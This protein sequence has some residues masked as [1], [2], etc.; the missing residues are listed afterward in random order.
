[1]INAI[2]AMDDNYAIGYS[3]GSLLFKIPE[4]MKF[5]SETT[6]GNTVIMGR[7]TYD[8]IGRALPNRFNLVISSEY[9][10]YNKESKGIYNLKFISMDEAIKFCKWFKRPKN[11][12]DAYII[13]GALIYN[14]FIPMCDKL[15]ITQYHT[16]YDDSDVR[17][18]KFLFEEIYT[19]RED[20]MHG[21]YNGI[22][23]DIYCLTK[24][25]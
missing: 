13:G 17:I 4:D 19:K 9:E 6:S 7:K 23:Y 5:F 20:I 15:Y 3:N 8:S 1:M 21:E 25:E 22:P 18:N 2:W 12:D 24:D 11:M 14:K 16:T 10:K